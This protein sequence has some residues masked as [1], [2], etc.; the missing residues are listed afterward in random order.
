[1]LACLLACLRLLLCCCPS[2]KLVCDHDYTKTTEW[3][4]MKLGRT[5]GLGPEKTPLTFGVDS[6]KGM[7]LGI[8]SSLSLTLQDRVTG[9]SIS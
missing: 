5:M 8:S 7:N 9:V 3:I 4:F 6:D 1:M 2:P